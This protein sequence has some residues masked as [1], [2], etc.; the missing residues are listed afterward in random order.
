MLDRACAPLVRT[1]CSTRSFWG[2]PILIGCEPASRTAVFCRKAR[3]RKAESRIEQ[4]RAF[5]RLEF[6]VSDAA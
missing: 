2:R 4:L 5:P 6:A 3:D 1:L